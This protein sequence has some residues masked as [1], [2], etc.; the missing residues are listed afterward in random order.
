[1]LRFVSTREYSVIHASLVSKS[2]TGSLLPVTEFSKAPERIT[3][4]LVLHSHKPTAPS[5]SCRIS[6]PSS[7]PWVVLM[8]EEQLWRNQ[9]CSHLFF[10][11]YRVPVS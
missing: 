3:F 5:S 8:P 7:C 4:F 6:V 2:Q 9:S 11:V 1:M 10:R